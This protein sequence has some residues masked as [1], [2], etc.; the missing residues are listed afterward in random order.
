MRSSTL[1]TGAASARGIP[2]VKLTT[3]KRI[4]ARQN[5]VVRAEGK[6]VREYNENDDKISVPGNEGNASGDPNSVY[7]DELPPV[8]IE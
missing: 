2:L 4:A 6:I 1:P 7:A 3:H 5:L 8:R